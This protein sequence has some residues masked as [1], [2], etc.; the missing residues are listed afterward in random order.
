[1]TLSLLA[2][3]CA[4]PFIVSLGTAGSSALPVIFPLEGTIYATFNC[5]PLLLGSSESATGRWMALELAFETKALRDICES[6]AIAKRELG[7]K[8]AD[9]LKRRL[10]DFRSIDTFD[11]LPFAKTKKSSNNITFDLP[12][13]WQLVVTG[14]HGDNP[15]LTSGKIDWTKV[16]R[17]K[18]VRIEKRK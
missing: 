10:S 3:D 6:E 8:V 11:E 4:Q 7:A 9:A 13:D 17:L 1:L 12:D 2:T 18:I 15:K 5:I 16:T 14:G